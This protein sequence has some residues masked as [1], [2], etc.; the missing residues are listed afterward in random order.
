MKSESAAMFAR[1]KAALMKTGSSLGLYY[2][3]L[4]LISSTMPREIN[5]TTWLL[6]VE[7]QINAV[8]LKTSESRPGLSNSLSIMT[9]A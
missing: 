7:A 2:Y 9:K 8:S 5:F 3:S 4:H 6:Q 1:A